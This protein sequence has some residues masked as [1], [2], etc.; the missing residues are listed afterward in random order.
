MAPVKTAMKPISEAVSLLRSLKLTSPTIITL[1]RELVIPRV[2]TRGYSTNTQLKSSR[3]KNQYLFGFN[4]YLT[5]PNFSL[6]SYN[7]I[8]SEKVLRN[9]GTKTP[10]MAS[11]TPNGSIIRQNYHEESEAHINKQINMELYAS[12]VYM[13]MAY[14]FD[15]EDVAL[16]GFYEYFKKQSD[17]EREHAEK[18]MKY[19]NKRGG[20]IVLQ[21]IAKPTRDE[22]SGPL[23]AVTAALELEKTVNQTLLDLHA[24][25]SR[26]GDPQL[27]DFL[28]TEFLEEQVKS[29]KELAG[30]LTNLNRVGKGLGEFTYD[31]E[32]NEKEN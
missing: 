7:V 14:Y 8:N 12:Y 13:S 25:G 29:I 26:N 11:S 16:P 4:C 21:Q 6:N 5:S 30:H 19:Q 20:R 10:N 23:E 18:F 3:H 9:F 22:W 1:L 28:E 24:V 15:R 2:Q 27:C 17:E 31:K 32:I